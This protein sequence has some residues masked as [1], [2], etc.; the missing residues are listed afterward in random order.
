MQLSGLLHDLQVHEVLGDPR[1][2]EVRSL[3]HVSSEVSAGSLFCCVPGTKVDGHDFAAAAVG[4]GAVGLVVER[5]V[6]VPVV[7]VRVPSTRRAMPWLAAALHGHPSRHLD[8]VGITGTNGKTTTAQMVRAILAAD[9][10]SVE[11]LGNLSSGSLNTPEGPALQAHLAGL[12][13]AS[14]TAVVM[15]VSSEGLAQ[16]RADAVA[17]DVAVFTML[18]RDH[19]NFHGTI[20]RYF[21]AKAALFDPERAA[22][23]VVNADDAHGRRLIEAARIPMTTFSMSDAEALETSPAGSQFRWR[24]ADVT[25]R[26]LG[27]FNVSNALA[28]ATACLVLD[29][30]P[31]TIAEALS[32]LPPVRGRMEPVDAGQPFTVLV[33]YAHTPDALQAVLGTAR[34]A[35]SSGRVLVVFG[36]GGDR[37]RGKRGPMGQVAATLSDMAVLTDDNPRSEDSS[38]IIREV[39]AGVGQPEEV[40]T[41]PD[42]REAIAYALEAARPG[43]V[44]VIAGKGHETGQVYATETRPFDD[45]QVALELLGSGAT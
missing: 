41:I 3:T 26:L 34:E 5:L 32:D 14:V 20:E 27:R 2:V 8:M 44:V 15:E 39:L 43:D 22:H 23:G 18:A 31:S 4:A 13:A 17:F 36:C 19:L 28:A 24:G 33:D 25:L 45:R 11:A 6:D 29:V 12:L 7:Q 30:A 40:R 1:S 10:R 38:A 16:H 42:R 21:Q 37:D 35:A 9:G